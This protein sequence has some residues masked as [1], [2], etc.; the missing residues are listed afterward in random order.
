ML[1]LMLI[2]KK[3]PSFFGCEEIVQSK[4]KIFTRLRPIRMLMQAGLTLSHPHN[5]SRVSQSGH[6]VAY[7]ALQTVLAHNSC[8]CMWIW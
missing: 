5:S 1:A 3:D 4:L 6:Q 8:V 7:Q 2:R